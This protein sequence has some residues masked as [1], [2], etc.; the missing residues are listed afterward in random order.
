M[1]IKTKKLQDM[2]ILRTFAI[3][4]I[5]GFHSLTYLQFPYKELIYGGYIADIGL[6]LFLFISGF[7]LY[8]NYKDINFK[9]GLK[10]FYY[11]R[12]VRIYPLYWFALIVTFA[13]L[14]YAYGFISFPTN[15]PTAILSFSTLL[16]GVLGLQGLTEGNTGLNLSLFWFIGV[17]LI[18]YFL[19]PFFTKP[20]N[21]INMFSVSLILF[22]ALYLLSFKLNIITL[23]FFFY[24]MFFAGIAICW[25]NDNYKSFKN[26]KT[27]FKDMTFKR[28]FEHVLPLLLLIL[29]LQTSPNINWIYIIILLLIT[30]I[31]YA[32]G[33]FLVSYLT[34]DYRGFFNSVTYSIITK[35]SYGSYAIYLLHVTIFAIIA[36]MIIKF[37]LNGFQNLIFLSGIPISFIVG[38]YVQI[39][40]SKLIR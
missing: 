1:T 16:S 39:V 14:I 9:N 8:Y 37:Q 40:E 20:K 13:S 4:L 18:Y 26:I 7:L 31:I 11:K 38:Y 21:L 35:I 2:E 25:L 15:Q 29:L 30:L 5:V 17:I 36:V 3:I 23:L 34:K 27:Y 32:M 6:S 10:T 22:F 33:K 28:L 24:W 12:A 19:Y